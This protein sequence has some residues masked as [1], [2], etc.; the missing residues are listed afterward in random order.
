MHYTDA[1]VA[2]TDSTQR[3]S[4]RVENYVR[5]RPGYPPEIL[6]VLKTECGLT[7]GSVIADVGSGTGFLSRLF[8]EHGNRVYGIEPNAEMREAGDRLLKQYAG[9]TSTSGTAEATGVPDRS[10]DFITAGQAAHWFD[11]ERAR[12]EFARILKPEGWTV[13]VWND[14]ATDSTH[15]LREYE[16][17][18]EE[19]GTDYHQVRHA[20]VSTWKE[21]GSFFAP[22][23]V[24]VRKFT[25]Q[26]TFD[27]AGLE[28][29]LLSSSYTPQEEHPNF[30]P[31][32]T[33]LRRIFDLYQQGG[34]VAMEYETRMYYAQLPR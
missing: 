24:H 4:S 33:E 26:Q 20:G 9:F 28:G 3:F 29:R 12:N 16:R 32:L 21:I 2:I 6:E 7:S 11:R 23:H 1:A 31:M 15:L 8:L 18:L 30:R 19:Y 10:V 25:N 34:V 14:R 13:L 17:L 27:Y 5:Y 22:A